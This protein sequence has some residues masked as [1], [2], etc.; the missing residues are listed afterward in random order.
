[1]NAARFHPTYAGPALFEVLL[2]GSKPL[3]CCFRKTYGYKGADHGVFKLSRELPKR[4][5]GQVLCF[6]EISGLSRKS[7]MN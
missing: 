3:P 1:M 7:N 6:L 5:S 2:D 4:W